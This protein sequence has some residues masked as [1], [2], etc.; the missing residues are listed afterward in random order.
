MRL[1]SPEDWRGRP[2]IIGH[3]RYRNAE[4]NPASQLET[5]KL[6]LSS[7]DVEVGVSS[8]E[9]QGRIFFRINIKVESK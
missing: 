2:S 4:V 9:E 3:Q 7:L 6:R 1:Y 8:I 5:Y